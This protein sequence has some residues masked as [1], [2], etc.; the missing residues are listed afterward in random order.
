VNENQ[1]GFLETR[2]SKQLLIVLLEFIFFDRKEFHANILLCCTMIAQY[3]LKK[4]HVLTR[5]LVRSLN[6]T[7]A[8]S[9]TS[10]HSYKKIFKYEL[11]M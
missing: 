6:H 1:S 3:S 11:S 8:T 7:L 9:M 10:L 2:Q 4:R 5:I